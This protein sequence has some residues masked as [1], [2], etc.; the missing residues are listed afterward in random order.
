MLLKTKSQNLVAKIKTHPYFSCL[1]FAFVITL[2]VA[3]VMLALLLSPT[4]RLT[5][6]VDKEAPVKILETIDEDPQSKYIMMERKQ[7]IL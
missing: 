4:E 2:L 6:V 7:V 5:F 3:V 1:A